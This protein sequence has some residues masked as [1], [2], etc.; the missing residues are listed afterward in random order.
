MRPL[1]VSAPRQHFDVS[2]DR[3][4]RSGSQTLTEIMYRLFLGSP[5]YAK[6]LDLA[7]LEIGL[8]ADGRLEAF[9]E[10][11]RDVSGR[12][13]ADRKG[14]VA[15]AMSEAS[16]AMHRL[17]PEVYATPTAWADGTKGK[18]DITPGLLAKRVTALT[19][20]RKPGH[21]KNAPA[22]VERRS[23]PHRHRD[24]REGRADERG[25]LADEHP[26]VAGD[27]ERP[28]PNAARATRLAR[29]PAARA[30]ARPLGPTAGPDRWARPL[31]PTAGPDRW[32]RPLGPSVT[33]RWCRRRAPQVPEERC[34]SPK[35]FELSRKQRLRPLTSRGGGEY[36]DNC[37]I[38][39]VRS[40]GSSR[41]A[42]FCG[43]N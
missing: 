6:D 36:P 30:S 8:E 18:A 12:E 7:E 9:E 15:F 35:C 4:I 25:A 5:G 41:R 13:W 16:A 26:A 2:T 28:V 3:G 37:R 11:F 23:F 1:A 21:A 22:Q 10:A 42:H 14:L 19:A 43:H 39:A 29:R 34:P 33:G 17:E 31:G 32:A 38:E 27:G 24:S 40:K 20:K